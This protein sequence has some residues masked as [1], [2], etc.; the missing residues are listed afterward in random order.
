[1]VFKKAKRFA[2]LSRRNLKYAYSKISCA[3]HTGSVNWNVV[4]PLGDTVVAVLPIRGAWIETITV[5]PLPWVI[6][7][8]PCWERELKPGRWRRE[9]TKEQMLPMRRELKHTM[10]IGAIKLRNV[11]HA[12]SM[13]WNNITV[14]LCKQRFCA[15]HTGSMNWNNADKISRTFFG[16]TP[17]ARSM[18]WNYLLTTYII[19]I[20]VLPMRGA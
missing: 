12:G 14:K 20:V 2:L 9:K 8:S 5:L 7:C 17:H 13:N 16:N 10:S 19:E 3:P 11:P 18:N 6:T 1:M 4:I 15:H